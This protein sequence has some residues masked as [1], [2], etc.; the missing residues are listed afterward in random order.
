MSE[1]SRVLVIGARRRRQGIGGFVAEKFHLCG[2]EICAIVG[3]SVESTETARRELTGRGVPCGGAYTELQE[4]IESS[5]PDIVAIC[6]PHEHHF[7]ALRTVA[8]Y[9]VHCLCEKPLGWDESSELRI[10]RTEEAVAEFATGR[11]LLDLVT[12]WPETLDGYF[13]LY[14][15]LRDQPIERFEMLLSPINTGPTMVPDAAPHPISMLQHLLG[16]G[17]IGE[18][19]VE[20]SSDQ[21]RELCLDFTYRHELGTTDVRLLCATCERSPRPAGFGLNGNW[22]RRKV[23]LPAYNFWLEKAERAPVPGNLTGE[24]AAAQGTGALE[25]QDPLVALIQR[26][27]ARA[28]SGAETD[29]RKLV[30]SMQGLNALARVVALQP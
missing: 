4:A 10:A 20:Y 9:D 3:T 22:V 8:K 7:D 30:E 6:T 24:F 12:Q 17:D 2:A 28:A 26:F 16:H 5:Q 29:T 21:R 15:E 18:A 25:I 27:L 13:T 14:P 11:R 19:R 1:K 23:E